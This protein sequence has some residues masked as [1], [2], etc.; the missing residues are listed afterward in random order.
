MFAY[1]ARRI[2]VAIP[3]VL[4][5]ATAGFL[6]I[7]MVPGDPGRIQLGPRASQAQVDALNHRYGLDRPLLD[8]YW[9]FLKGAVQL[10]F[11]TSFALRQSVGSALA[12]RAVPSIL[13]AG[14]GLVIAL[15]LAVPLAFLSARRQNRAPDHVVRIVGMTF[16]AMPPFWLGLMLAVIF[17]LQLG[18]LP[19]SGYDDSSGVAILRSLTLPAVT[20]SLIVMPLFIRTLRAS[21]IATYGA[22]FVESA[23]ARGLS[24]RRVLWRHVFR[25]SSMS[26]VTLVGLVAGFLVSSTVVVESVFAIP[27]VGQLLVSSVGARDFPVIAGLTVLMGAAVV[28]INLLTD[29]VYGLVDPRVRY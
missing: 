18:W 22:G 1:V 12:S 7:H 8:Q 15:L 10:D 9:S 14:L 26:L 21:V 17:G 25:N 6:L 4:L 11:G 24:H 2:L 13:L 19:T 28:V 5:I 20:V 3:L 16:Y 23:R 27:G 29:I